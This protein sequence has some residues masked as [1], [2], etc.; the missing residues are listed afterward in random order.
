MD[1]D[2]Q[3]PLSGLSVV[4]TGEVPGLDRSQ[5]QDGVGALGGTLAKS[6]GPRTDLVVAGSGAGLSKMSKARQYNCLVLDADTFAALLADPACWSGDR[7]GVP[8][9]DLPTG[10][11]P[12]DDGPVV[13]APA[14]A[15]PGVIAAP[16]D[17]R[18]HRRAIASVYANGVREI[19][20]SCFD[21]GASW[22]G[23]QPGLAANPCPGNTLVSPAT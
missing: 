23:E 15:E 2:G 19:R 22:T 21:C 3:L 13:G 6:V 8:A 17:Q 12:A 5:A 14:P 16:P 9:R 20:L 10:A 4:V 7:L 1:Q 11:S 18:G